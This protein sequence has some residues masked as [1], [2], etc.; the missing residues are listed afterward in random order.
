MQ[1]H[2]NP[3]SLQSICATT[4]WKWGPSM[5]RLRALPVAKP[6]QNNSRW[7]PTIPQQ[8]VLRESGL[9]IEV[10]PNVQDTIWV[11]LCLAML[12]TFHLVTLQSLDIIL[13]NKT[14]LLSSVVPSNRRVSCN[15][16]NCFWK[17]CQQSCLL[18]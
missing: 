11:R 4:G 15:N 18:E 3:F 7:L 14:R 9:K 10:L 17:N 6:Q 12:L 5:E 16:R 1:Q 13:L 2:M 8:H